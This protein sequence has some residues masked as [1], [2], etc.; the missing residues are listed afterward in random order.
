MNL[1][2]LSI[3]FI[4]PAFTLAVVIVQSACSGLPFA[5]PTPT[6]TSYP[7]IRPVKPTRTPTFSPTS[8][9]LPSATPT[10]TPTPTLLPPLDDFSQARLYSS[11]PIPGWDFSLTILLPKPIQGEYNA[12]VGNEQP[13]LFTCRPLTEYAHPDRLYC[14]GRIPAADKQVDYS[15]VEKNT[16]QE[17]FKGN[18][19]API[20]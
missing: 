17:V 18:V 2:K 3:N 10:I 8:T 5:K 7:T 13:K 12:L 11:G 19:Y 16:G 20:K 6:M 1:S 15:I 14:I 9:A 4:I